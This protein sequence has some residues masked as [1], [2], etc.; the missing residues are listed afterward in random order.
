MRLLIATMT[1]NRRDEMRVHGSRARI[2]RGRLI[3]RMSNLDV[4]MNNFLWAEP[5]VEFVS[6][7]FRTHVRMLLRTL[8]EWW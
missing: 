3:D 1:V 7:D 2:H 6:G 4:R 5:L 8:I